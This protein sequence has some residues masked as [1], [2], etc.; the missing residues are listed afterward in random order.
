M[1]AVFI[2]LAPTPGFL[3]SYHLACVAT[4]HG[5]YGIQKAVALSY[6][7]VAWFVAMGTTVVVGSIFAISEHVSFSEVAAEKDKL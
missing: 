3:G 5:I 4:L 7:I 2:T 6:G 1:V